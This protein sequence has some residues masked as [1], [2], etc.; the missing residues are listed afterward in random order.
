MEIGN[1]ISRSWQITWKYKSLWLF[2]VILMA[3]SYLFSVLQALL[4]LGMGP[5]DLDRVGMRQFPEI[6]ILLCGYYMVFIVV[7]MLISI[8]QLIGM[9]RGIYLASAQPESLTLGEIVREVPARI[10]R[11]VLFYL[12]TFVGGL[13]LGGIFTGL[14]LLSGSGEGQ[15]TFSMVFLCLLCVIIPAAFLLGLVYY[16]AMIALV[17]DDLGIFESFK[18]GWDV[19]R[20]NLGTYIVLMLVV[21]GISIVLLIVSA[22]VSFGMLASVFQ[23]MFS[24]GVPD[25]SM[26]D[27]Q[28][29]WHFY[30][31]NL[32]LA[33]PGVLI[34]I[35]T[36]ALFVLTYLDLTRTSGSGADQLPADPEPLL[37]LS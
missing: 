32:L 27:F 18:K 28:T 35:F 30:L 10:G 23:G 34:S 1:V 3:A 33:V 14:I 5:A 29:P 16:Q 25:P 4:P 31:V 8:V 2:A 22:S 12:V 37:E 19:V 7:S 26:V 9:I 21:I 17:V 11:V 13:L 6:S 24:N 20:N 15:Q 36:M